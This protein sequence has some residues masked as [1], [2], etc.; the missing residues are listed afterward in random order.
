MVLVLFDFFV[1]PPRERTI[2]GL[3]C[4]KTSKQRT[5]EQREERKDK[6]DVFE[7]N[8]DVV[9]AA[10]YE[11]KGSRNARRRSAWTRVF[12]VFV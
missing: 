12:H 10:E 1:F 6:K 2:V 11:G 8:F 4:D 9:G 3:C 7:S 5:R